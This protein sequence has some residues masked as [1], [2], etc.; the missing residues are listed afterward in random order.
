MIAQTETTEVRRFPRTEG[1]I[2]EAI[3]DS[4]TE[5]G[6][7]VMR[8]TSVGEYLQMSGLYDP[9]TNVA[10]WDSSITAAFQR[11]VLPISKNAIKQR[12]LR[13]L[14]R[15]GTVPAIVLFQ[16]DEQ[17]RHW[18]CSCCGRTCDHPRM[19]GEDVAGTTGGEPYDY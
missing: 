4:A 1:D 12:M 10:N 16:R 3:S 2:S 9:K 18:T 5:K 15:G 6:W 11:A 17:Q 8:K 14:M 13:D 7:Y 19:P